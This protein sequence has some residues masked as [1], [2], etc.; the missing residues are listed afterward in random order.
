[1]EQVKVFVD[2]DRRGSELQSKVNRWLRDHPDI[3]ITSHHVS[4]AAAPHFHHITIVI[5]YHKKV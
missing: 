5:F 3:N 1:M 4:S 2:D